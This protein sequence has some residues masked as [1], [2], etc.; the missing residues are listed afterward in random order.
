MK[1][2]KGLRALG[3]VAAAGAVITAVSVAWALGRDGADGPRTAFASAPEGAYLVLARLTADR[4]AEVISVAPVADP[5]AEMPIATIDTLDDFGSRGSVSPDGTKLA[6]VT[7]DAGTASH[8]GAS[9]LLVDLF[10]GEVTRLAIAVDLLQ[11]PLWS[12]DGSSLIVT[13][14]AATDGPRADVTVWRVAIDLS[15]EEAV[16][17]HGQVLGAYAV[18]FDPEGR[19]VSVVI[20]G[21]GSRVFRGGEEVTSLG[22]YITRDWALSPDGSAL[23]Y[24]EAN[25]GSGLAYYPRVVALDGSGGPAA[26]EAAAG[27]A[28]GA[29]WAPDGVAVFGRE[30]AGGVTAQEAAGGG[31][32]IPREYAPDGSA[33]VVQHWT[34]SSL[35]EPGVPALQV[36]SAAGR[37]AIAG[38]AEFFGWATR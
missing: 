22:P 1:A 2:A 33:S 20:D 23:A 11:T 38:G 8:P 34:G 28:L 6:L 26:Q 25:T 37:A 7:P 19:L 31:F 5:A 3:W 35:A 27:Q 9:L 32:D 21:S 12:P 30:P 15:G 18:G 29:A 4:T 14:T 17:S 10:S 16:A 13:R 36:V 24:V